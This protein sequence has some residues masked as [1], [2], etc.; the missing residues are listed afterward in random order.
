MIIINDVVKIM[1]SYFPDEPDKFDSGSIEPYMYIYGP[2]VGQ[3]GIPDDLQA[4][5][6]ALLIL[7]AINPG[8]SSSGIVS[9]KIKDIEIRYASSV[10]TLSPWMKLYRALLYGDINI[11]DDALMYVGIGK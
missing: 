5:G 3:S 2:I 11:D 6:L 9:K 8:G 7:D 10:K 4:L 1:N